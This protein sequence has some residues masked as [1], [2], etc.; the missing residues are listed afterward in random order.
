MSKK[1]IK[2]GA[3]SGKTYRIMQEIVQAL[4]CP[5]ANLHIQN[6]LVTTFTEK[7]ALELKERI[8]DKLLEM[9]M[10]EELSNLSEAKIGTVHSICAAFLKQYGYLIEL[11]PNLEVISQEE[12]NLL[13]LDLISEEVNADAFTEICERLEKIDFKTKLA[14]YPMEIISIID[15]AKANRIS[16]ASLLEKSLSNSVETYL[17]L[18]GPFIEL[19]WD[20][21][22]ALLEKLVSG[23]VG[24]MNYAYVQDFVKSVTV[25]INETEA[26]ATEIKFKWS[27]VQGL[28]KMIEGKPKI[29]DV[30]TSLDPNLILLNFHKW[31]YFKNDL[32]Q[33]KHW[34]FEA[35]ARILTKYDQR[36]RSLGLMDFNDMEAYMLDLLDQPI[37]Q[38]EFS[39]SVRFVLVDEFQDT[40]PIQAEI[41]SK[42]HEFA[43]ASFWV[44]D[45]K[46]SIYRFRG[47]DL[48]FVRSI[49]E[50]IPTDALETSF[51]SRQKIVEL[52]N[53]LF[54][55][56]FESTGD[57][58]SDLQVSRKELP[59]QFA[60]AINYI[61]GYQPETIAES[62]EK[63]LSNANL[64]PVQEKVTGQFRQLEASD[65]AILV[66]SNDEVNQVISALIKRNIP[67]AQFGKFLTKEDE[68]IFMNSILS[69]IANPLDDFAISKIAY[70]QHFNLDAKAWTTHRVIQQQNLRQNEEGEV[71]LEDNDN[72]PIFQANYGSDLPFIQQLGAFL[73]KA[74]G[75]GITELIDQ[76]ILQFN[77]DNLV[78]QWGRAEIRRHNLNTF[79][80]MAQ[81]YQTYCLH[82][83]KIQSIYGFIAYLEKISQSKEFSEPEN[84]IGVKVLT[85]HRSKGLEYPMLIAAG[86]DNTVRAKNIYQ[87]KVQNAG[88]KQQL[89]GRWIRYFVD[90]FHSKTTASGYYSAMSPLET[91]ERQE[92]KKEKLR[93]LYVGLT[94]PRDYLIF[95]I[96]T[97]SHL[98]FDSKWMSEC[99]GNDDWKNVLINLGIDSIDS[100]K[101]S[102][103]RQMVQSGYVEQEKGLEVALREEAVKEFNKEENS[104]ASNLYLPS[105]PFQVLENPV[106][107][108]LNP[109]KNRVDAEL[110]LGKL[111]E[112]GKVLPKLRSLT[113]EELSIFGDMIHQVMVSH[114]LPQAFPK[115]IQ[116]YGFEEVVNSDHLE[117]MVSNFN[118]WQRIHFSQHLAWPELPFQLLT[119]EGQL[120]NGI[121]DLALESAEGWVL[122]D[123]KTYDGLAHE[124]HVLSEGYL[125]QLAYYQLALE[126]LSG[127][128]VLE[129]YLHFPVTGHVMEIAK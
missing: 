40:N 120:I 113:P 17:N 19:E 49:T 25:F 33:Y 54:R 128:P 68:I 93:L 62:V 87:A 85:Y 127:K 44:G 63:I 53:Q 37:F 5:D 92:E 110:T 28:V 7:A 86:M 23:L 27:A 74:R 79:R 24:I 94:R 123:H 50:N 98:N 107:F 20:G 43:G 32:I 65:V 47:A 55:P 52:A 41:F 66:H 22:K 78:S 111:M 13:L 117:C 102:S 105:I 14:V 124:S 70:Y 100:Y 84:P 101:P 83:G 12:R 38:E 80:G 112:I 61:D 126:K 82:F 4:K 121:I 57:Y 30:Y 59:N 58:P 115:L 116:Q 3:G 129:T 35:A 39:N 1:Y 96:S 97:K 48:D 18:Q 21:I 104:K 125:S 6:C 122:I 31:V 26:E 10:Y 45:N 75:L 76:L 15:L 118:D 114:R 81:E 56:I 77:L 95:S 60:N 8:S 42:W 2:A 51:R 90:P 106:S 91:L 64:W 109:S 67:V 34:L 11:S 46:Q 108:L 69:F 99:L 119:E 72:Q 36:K 71:Y 88:E 9:N 16:A 29:L 73:K 89:E 103:D